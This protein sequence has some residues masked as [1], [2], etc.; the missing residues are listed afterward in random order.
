MVDN[1]REQM[2]KENH[3]LPIPERTLQLSQEAQESYQR[4]AKNLADIVQKIPKFELPKIPD[5][6]KEQELVE[7]ASPD[8]IREQNAWERHKEMIDIQNA[9]LGVQGKLL[10][11]Q[12]SN[13]RF[14]KIV[15]GLSVLAI[16]VS[17]V[18]IF[19]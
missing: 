2:N 18:S 3:T 16:I 6:L 11:E 14:T 5:F 1:T 8:V 15:I 17:V 12:K 9:L 4:L 10:D 7:L 19:L 13:T